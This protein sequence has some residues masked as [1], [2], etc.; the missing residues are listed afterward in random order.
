MT[1]IL[2][3]D[4]RAIEAA[5]PGRGVVA[6]AGGLAVFGLATYGYLG[7][8]GRALEAE[9]FAP[10]SVLWTLL[11]AIGIG[12]FLPFEQE[13]G[14][15][16][17]ARRAAGEGN[18]PVVRHS[19]RAALVLLGVVALLTAVATGSL[20]AR[21]F[22]GN[23]VLVLLF[24]LALAGMAAAYLIRGLLSGGGFFGRY[25]AQLAADGVIRAVWAGALFASGSQDLAAYGVVL[26]GAPVLA[27]LL[28]TPRLSRIVEPGPAHDASVAVAALATLIGASVLSQLLA[29]A[30]PVVVQLL[31]GPL[32]Q[33]ASGQFTAAL[34]IARV[35][36]FAFAAVQAVLLPGLAAL[37]GAGEVVRF[38][39][40]VRLVG[41]VTLA[42][43]LVGT[44][45]V[46]ILG[47]RLV[48]LLFG[49]DF[50]IARVVITLIA[51]S[52]AAFMIAQVLAQA[53]LALG[54][55]RWVLVGWAA[56]LATLVAAA[57]LGPG[58]LTE[59]AAWALVVG[60]MAAVAVLSVGLVRRTP[61]APSVSAT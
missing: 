56:G 47:A 27:V 48:P 49:P 19:A 16:T 9:V 35:P 40:R 37:V 7:F 28:T 8:A 18:A 3:E 2:G 60:G 26:V 10:L 29:N 23:G 55:D 41:L 36:L 54:A 51:L 59:R 53:L 58:S 33:E 15:R 30:G 4:R 5:G 17:A 21:L 57:L 38:R 42:L 11:N 25:G 6:V 50:S 14:R 44:A 39:E 61:R 32:D 12:L 52:G 24:V 13:L 43:G 20:S 1:E 45:L 46:W 34:V 22:S 31:A